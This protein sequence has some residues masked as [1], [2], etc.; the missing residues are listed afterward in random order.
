MGLLLT[1][2]GPTHGSMQLGGRIN[3]DPIFLHGNIFNSFAT[4]L[5]L[6][7]ALAIRFGKN[8]PKLERYE[9]PIENF[10][11]AFLSA[12]RRSLQFTESHGEGHRCCPAVST[13]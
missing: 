3:Y 9:N 2:W 1:F 4:A 5:N 11:H 6:N 13:R 12:L 10:V 8:R 7:L